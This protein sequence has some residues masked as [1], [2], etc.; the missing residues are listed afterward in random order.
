MNCFTS[1]NDD[2]NTVINRNHISTFFLLG[3]LLGAAGL[4]AQ[5]DAVAAFDSGYVETGN[6]FV[7]HISVPQDYGQPEQVDFSPWD[8]LL[9]SQNIINQT[10][11]QQANGRWV[12]HF[13]LL[14]FDSAQLEL[15]PLGLNFAGG[16]YLQTN[17]LSLNVLPTPAPNDPAEMQEIKDIYREPRNWL[18]FLVPYWPIAAGVLLLALAIWWLLL[19]KKKTGL[20]GERLIRQAPH[21]LALRKL[22]D[23]ERQRYWQQGQLK[24]YYSELTHIAR[25]YLERRYRVQ[26]LESPSDEMLQA[27]QKTDLPE[28]WLP[29]LTELLR[30]ADLAKFAKGTPPETYHLQ[31]FE[32][33]RRLVEKTKPQPQ[34]PET[35]EPTLTN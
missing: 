31:A 23:L 8:T 18:D 14:A 13:T 16:D 30:W 27:L 5:N 33:V 2:N 26:A 9:P 28:Y 10:G 20:E 35:A 24:I 25:E 4:H 22:A 1:K 29:P 15:P 32:N 19:R 3:L 17:T 12:K 21:E 34:E 11:W 6:P 7:L